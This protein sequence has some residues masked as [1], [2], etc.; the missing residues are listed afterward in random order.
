MSKILTFL[1]IFLEETMK[2]ILDETG[3]TETQ[4]EML[5]KRYT[6]L[7]KDDKGFLTREDF[8][9]I[10]ELAINPVSKI[11]YILQSSSIIIALLFQESIVLAPLIAAV[12]IQNKGFLAFPWGLFTNCVT[13]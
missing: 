13:H 11:F 2:K 5:W 7:D 12:S 10:P 8:L 9:S 3:F 4:V 6:V 1:L